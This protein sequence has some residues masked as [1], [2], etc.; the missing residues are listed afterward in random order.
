LEEGGHRSRDQQGIEGYVV[1]E[2]RTFM[3]GDELAAFVEKV[4]R[5]KGDGMQTGDIARRLGVSRTTL[6]SRLR[7][8]KEST[9]V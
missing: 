1:S 7:R 9:R 2:N 8:Y 3:K 6:N 5:L 4:K